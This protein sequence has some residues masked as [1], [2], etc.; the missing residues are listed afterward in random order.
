[1]KKAQQMG[2]AFEQK[3]KMVE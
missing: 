1:M 3:L 2:K